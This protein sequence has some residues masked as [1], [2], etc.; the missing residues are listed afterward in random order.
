VRVERLVE[1]ELD[2]YTRQAMR[3]G[4]RVDPGQQPRVARAVRDALLH[5]GGFQ[6]FLDDERVENITCIGHDMV[7]VTYQDGRK[8]RVEPV[9][10]SDEE[11]V[12]LVRQIAAHA[13]AEERRFDRA[14]PR[15]SAQLPDGSR[16]FAT[17]AVSRRPSVAIR[18]HRYLD[19][20]LADL[21]ETGTFDTGM[22]DLLAALVLARKNLVI[23]GGAD[24]GKTTLLRALVR[25][26][27]AAE[28]LVT[29]EDSY[30]LALERHR[31]DVTAFQ[32]REP[33]VEGAGEVSAAELVRWALRMNPS[34]VIVGETRGPEVLP[35]C[36]AMSQGNDGSLATIH[37]SS[38]KGALMRM[39]TYAV[40][41]PER[42]GLEAAN[43]L[44]AGAV[45]V[46]VHL[47]RRERGAPRVVSSV[48]EV[49]GA[50]GPQI[51]TNELFRPTGPE[52]RATPAGVPPSPQ[53]Y[54][55]LTAVGA[56]PFLFDTGRAP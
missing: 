43:L 50:D 6:R 21:R 34:R 55:D 11:L 12:E 45:H 28:R 52:R 33:N 51:A 31:D 13:G 47:H 32:V 35:L 15:L 44:I 3:D 22:Q 9:A 30:E 8:V 4:H 39:A 49:A 56:P 24:V 54:E 19:A 25:Q 41:T 36:L 53:L 16:L 29:V 14:V 7:H 48:L 17:M 40:Q 46:V 2:A 38:S 23:S 18:R 5:L 27:P 10:G 26:I 37:A 20:D 42:L 1:E